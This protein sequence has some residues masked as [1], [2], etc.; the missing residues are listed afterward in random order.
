MGARLYIRRRML[1]RARGVTGVMIAG[2]TLLV[3]GALRL[4]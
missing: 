3:K 1:C 2:T 4:R